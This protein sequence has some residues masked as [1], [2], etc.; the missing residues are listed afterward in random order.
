MITIY[1]GPTLSVEKARQILPDADYRPPIIRGDLN[2]LP[3]GTRIVGIVDGVFFNE[4]AVGHKEIIATINKGV[5]MVGSSSMGALRAAELADF[6][7]IGVGRIYECYRS[8]RITNDDEVAVT[9]NPVTGEQIS[10]PL[11]NIRHQLK[12]AEDNGIITIEE[13]RSLVEMIGGMYY[14]E[15]IYPAIMDLAKAEGILSDPKVG[16]LSRHIREYPVSLKAEDAFL[17]LEK[18]K[19]LSSTM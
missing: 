9:F 2:F 5:T 6:G 18:I 4:T 8:G 15:R 11:V 3:K 7:M 16:A 14:P 1:T 12:A 19:E 10:Q 13:R 17:L